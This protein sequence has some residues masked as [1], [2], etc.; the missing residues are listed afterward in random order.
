MFCPVAVCIILISQ[1]PEPAER[2][3]ELAGDWVVTQADATSEQKVVPA[4]LLG[5]TP[6]GTKITVRG[7][8][9]TSG[10]KVLATLTTEFS[11]AGLDLDKAVWVGRRPV[12]LTLPTGKGFLCAYEYHDG[13]GLT[14][15]YPHTMG[16]ITQGT[17]LYVHRPA[18]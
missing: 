11:A 7:N 15:Y 16:R 6:K 17:W 2:L 8:E 3:K 13:T 9:L 1:L 12:M 4:D 10:G 5:L 14:I 18:K